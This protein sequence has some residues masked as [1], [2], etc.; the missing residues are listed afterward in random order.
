ML[1]VD[2]VLV[3]PGGYR[4]AL[5]ATL[6]YLTAQADISVNLPD[7]TTLAFC[8]SQGI[9][10]EWDMTP[11]LLGIILEAFLSHYP[12]VVLSQ[13]WEQAAQTIN[14]YHPRVDPVDYY[15]SIARV[16]EM[17]ESGKSISKVIYERSQ[18]NIEVSPFNRLSHEPLFQS[19][20]LNNEDVNQSI[21]TELLQ[22]YVLGRDIFYETYHKHARI[23]GP[24]FLKEYDKPLVSEKTILDIKANANDGNLTPVIYTARPSLPP[25]GVS[26]SSYGFSPEAELAVELVK[27]DEYPLIAY[28]RLLYLAK[29]LAIS[30]DLLAKPSPFQAL[31][32]LLAAELGEEKPA[33]EIAAEICRDTGW[34]PESMEMR[35]SRPYKQNK[36]ELVDAVLEKMRLSRRIVHI[37]E[38]SP[39]GIQAGKLACDLLSGLSVPVDLHPWGIAED[40][41]KKEALLKNG[42]LV[43]EKTDDALNAILQQV[44]L[45]DMP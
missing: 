13:E 18:S 1:D 40:H 34:I 30:T 26:F 3:R 39:V 45:I 5:L 22:N 9:T 35:E 38:D 23:S 16:A 27:M 8:E 11:L 32:A 33:L 36:R 44:R 10:N 24:S 25:R 17:Q 28:G 31:A 12:N 42:A 21:T 37:V 2:S 6:D 43:F 19:L 7:E 14:S 29:T 15:D 4:A 41:A 20:F